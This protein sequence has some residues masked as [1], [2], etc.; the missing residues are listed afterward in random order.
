[1]AAAIFGFARNDTLFSI[2]NIA[3]TAVSISGITAAV[4]LGID[5]WLLLR[6]STIDGKTFRVSTVLIV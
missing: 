3:R 4:G 6:Y 2:N 1:M 5:V